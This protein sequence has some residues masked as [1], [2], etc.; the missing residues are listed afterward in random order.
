MLRF[1]ELSVIAKL[2]R[3]RGC[4]CT[5]LCCQPHVLPSNPAS[6]SSYPLLSL[7]PSPLSPL[8]PSARLQTLKDKLTG[9]GK[10]I[11]ASDAADLNYD[12]LKA[13]L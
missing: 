11:Q 6:P 9:L 7:R 8:C 2:T 10:D 4:S 13:S 3:S 5:R 12:T 1:A